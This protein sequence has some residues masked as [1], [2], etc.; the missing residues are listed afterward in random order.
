MQELGPEV[1]VPVA[2][3][4]LAGYGVLAAAIRRLYNDGRARDAAIRPLVDRALIGMEQM[5]HGLNSSTAAD[6]AM[7]HEVAEMVRTFER[8]RNEVAGLRTDI[9]RQG[10]GP[11]TG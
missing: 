7:R 10:S 11:K 4:L 8:L 9:R 5:A 3:T 2:G 6:E 1:Y